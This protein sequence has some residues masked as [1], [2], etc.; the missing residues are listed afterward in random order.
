MSLAIEAKSAVSS[1]WKTMPA[2]PRVLRLS[3][4]SKVTY[5]VEIANNRSGAGALS[6]RRPR[7][8]SRSPKGLRGDGRAGLALELGLEALERGDALLERRVRR[9]ERR[10]RLAR[11]C[12]EDEERVH[13]L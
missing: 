1:G 2:T 12:G 11:A 10:Q 13:R 3:S 7:I 4:V 5:A 6:L 9:E 8:T